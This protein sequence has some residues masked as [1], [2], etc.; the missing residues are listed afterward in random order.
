MISIKIKNS[1][2][3][4][5]YVPMNP[6]CPVGIYLKKQTWTKH[7]PTL[8]AVKKLRLK[9]R[10]SLDSDQKDLVR[11]ILKLKH[12]NIINFHGIVVLSLRNVAFSISEYCSKGSLYDVLQ[13]I[14]NHLI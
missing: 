5:V 4:G 2:L 13:V 9:E 14:V 12:E 11:N 1:K 3:K 7:P 8:V 10:I 6:H